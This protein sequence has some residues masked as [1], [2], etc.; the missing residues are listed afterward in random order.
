MSSLLALASVVAFAVVSGIV[1]VRLLL[2]ARRSRQLP[3]LCVGLGLLMVGAIGYPLSLVVRVGL[4]GAAASIVT[5]ISVC[6]S[7]G[8]SMAIYFFTWSVFRRN[9]AWAK[10]LCAAAS[11]ALLAYAADGVFRA[12]TEAPG[13][14]GTVDG[15]FVVIQV[16]TVFSYAWT[17]VESLHYYRMLR[18]RLTL[19][20]ADPV[21]A[22]RFY[23][24]F[25]SG[26]FA[27]AGSGIVTILAALG[28]QPYDSVLGRAAVGM[29]GL[30]ASIVLALAFV[31]PGAYLRWIARSAR[32]QG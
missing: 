9:A 26:V 6:A 7:A 1:G 27:S 20:L 5:A 18:R 2:L 31:P 10:G 3:E 19:G 24:W 32:T 23:L 12:F 8:G 11:A 4:S 30:G 29:G 28:S 21:V 17:A 14:L 13:W 15:W 25:L 16:T 22:N